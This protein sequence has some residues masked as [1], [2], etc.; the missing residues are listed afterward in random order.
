MENKKWSRVGLRKVGIWNSVFRDLRI[1]WLSSRLNWIITE[2]WRRMVSLSM[3]IPIFLHCRTMH[4]TWCCK[5]TRFLERHLVICGWKPPIVTTLGDTTRISYANNFSLRSR[6]SSDG[7][8]E[9][10]VLDRDQCPG[11]YRMEIHCLSRE[12]EVQ[13]CQEAINPGRI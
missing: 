9:F 12:V 8:P 6:A 10:W 13:G 5:S 3:C 4:G 7:R 2:I 1:C 11:P